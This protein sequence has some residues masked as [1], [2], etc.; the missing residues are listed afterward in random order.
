MQEN[1]YIKI[2]TPKKQNQ[3]FRE[4][5]IN[6]KEA[7]NN[8]AQCKDKEVSAHLNLVSDQ[9]TPQRHHK[10]QDHLARKNVRNQ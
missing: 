2:K 4:K 5:S 8:Q 7:N 3:E 1:N 9:L 10:D 6:S